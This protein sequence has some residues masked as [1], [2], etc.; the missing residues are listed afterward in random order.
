MS[1]A[2]QLAEYR[3]QH[4]QTFTPKSTAGISESST[5]LPLAKSAVK[6]HYSSKEVSIS[7][8]KSTKACLIGDSIV[9]TLNLANYPVPS[10]K[11]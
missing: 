3:L 8:N 4:N 2:D 1:W 11:G 9:R 7:A 10:G 5:R 6:A